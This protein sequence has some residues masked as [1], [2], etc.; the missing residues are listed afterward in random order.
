MPTLTPQM[1][2]EQAPRIAAV[3]RS[4]WLAKLR[5]YSYRLAWR[6]WE[7]SRGIDTSGQVHHTELGLGP[8]CFGYQP[9]DYEAVVRGLRA[10]DIR[11]SAEFLDYGCGKGRALLVAA[12]YPFARLW[13]VELAA[14]LSEAARTNLQRAPL[15]RGRFQVVEQ[16]A[17][18]FTVPDS[19]T[20]VFMFN[21]F[22]GEVLRQAVD[23]L[24]ESWQRRPRE[25]QVIYAIPAANE[26]YLVTV[27]WLQATRQV[28][29]TCDAWLNMTIYRARGNA[30]SEPDA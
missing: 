21:P 16:D 13:G 29:T 6:A 23:R 24:Y 4:T 2:Y 27:P 18:Q 10:V 7:R 19:V 8:E 15:A 25:L 30:D 17:T 5:R 1:V 22:Q 9:L 14:V 20:V 26:S 3:S 28:S 12:R 11:P